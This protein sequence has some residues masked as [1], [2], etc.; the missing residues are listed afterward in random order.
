MLTNQLGFL[1]FRL[2]VSYENLMIIIYFSGMIFVGSHHICS[3][4]KLS[5]T[6]IKV[7]MLLEN[8]SQ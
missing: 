4:Q 8:L 2:F 1:C 6:L 7:K 5:L 3:D